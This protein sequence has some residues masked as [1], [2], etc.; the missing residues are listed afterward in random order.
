MK[1][2]TL[3]GMK[4]PGIHVHGAATAH[5]WMTWQLLNVMYQLWNYAKILLFQTTR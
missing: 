1:K 5:K 3:S 2:H 4:H